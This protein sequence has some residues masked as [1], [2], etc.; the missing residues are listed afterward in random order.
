MAEQG[1]GLG[2]VAVEEANGGAIRRLLTGTQN[3]W[4]RKGIISDTGDKK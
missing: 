1:D 2:Q 3:G 4:N